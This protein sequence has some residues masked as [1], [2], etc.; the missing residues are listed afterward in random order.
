MHKLNSTNLKD[1]GE[2]ANCLMLSFVNSLTT[3]LGK[4]YVEKSLQWFLAKPNRFLFHI[5]DGEKV[6]G[7]CGGFA[8]QFYGDGSTSGM[9]QFAFSE[10]ILGIVKNPF[11]LFNSELRK[12]YPLILRNIKKK[13]GLIKSTA[14]KGP[15]QSSPASF[16][17]YIG[18][19]V[20]GVHPQNRG[21][22]VFEM[23]MNEFEHRA[24]AFDC[25]KCI[26]SV[27][28]NNSRAFNAYTKMGWQV[29]NEMDGIFTLVKFI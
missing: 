26:L 29:Q 19:V 21:T 11:L 5:Y 13:I 10:A 15:N 1:L 20:I 6:V 18:L 14:I 3:K 23:L 9:I 17:K 27:K 4:S 2:V 12:H 8:P 16:E 7:F 22:G 25:K 28:S 24:S